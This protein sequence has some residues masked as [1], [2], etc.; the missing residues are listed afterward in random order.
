MG[1]RH[2]IKE[3]DSSGDALHQRE[4][5]LNALVRGSPV[6]QFVID[7][8]HRIIHWNK[9]LEKYS[10]IKTEEVIGTNQHWRAFYPQERPCLADL[11]VDGATDRISELYQG[12]YAESA[13]VEGAYEAPGFFPHLGESGVW[14]YLTA[15]AIR[16]DEGRIIGA[17][18]T[19]EDIT[20][21]KKAEEAL[22]ESEERVRLKLESLLSPGG[23]IGTLEL[24]DI[25][26]AQELQ[27][28]M[29]DFYAITHMG[30]GIIDIRGNV[31]VGTGWQD[32]CTK[33]HRVNPETCANCIESDTLLT[34]GVEP[35]TFRKYKCKNNMWDIVTPIIVGGNHVGNIFLGQFL[36]DDESIDIELFRAQA[37]R[38][39]FDEQT[40]LAA[41][42]R[43]PRWSR[44]KVDTLMTFYAK[45]AGMISTLSYRNL[46][47]ART[48]S[49]RD[50]LLHSLRK[51]EERFRQVAE[52]AGE[53]IWEVDA[54][55]LYTYSSPAVEK[56][57]GYRPDEIVEIGRAHV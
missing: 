43:V 41:L 17:V 5:W 45:F 25:I 15:V 54:D 51:S 53:W 24:G 42:E 11:L 38:Y 14:L 20:R 39:G 34:E 8:D 56:M 21:R 37:A 44:E 32:I 57:L 52:S 26:D 55:G 33:F 35:G 50:T 40:Y 4:A 18:E 3:P 7:S 28:M 29:N 1:S 12:N 36:Y 27:S 13:L 9:A 46:L 23:D 31:L 10:G 48:V 6:P 30:I 22:R 19:L 2:R 49:E 47:L 16:D